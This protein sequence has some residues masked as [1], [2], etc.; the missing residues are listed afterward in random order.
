MKTFVIVE[1][2]NTEFD[3]N[4]F[5]YDKESESFFL[6]VKNTN[7]DL[8]EN[9]KYSKEFLTEKYGVFSTKELLFD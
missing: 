3:G 2:K 4:I 6:E 5:A 8:K 1:S 9:V 7:T